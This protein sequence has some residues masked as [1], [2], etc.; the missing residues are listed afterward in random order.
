MST[1][2]P[3]H[4]ITQPAAHLHDGQVAHV[5]LVSVLHLRGLR[6]SRPLLLLLLPAARGLCLLLQQQHVGQVPWQ[7]V[8]CPG[9]AIS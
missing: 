1:A 9:L 5:R 8:C 3:A 2:A 7:P 4:S 6:A